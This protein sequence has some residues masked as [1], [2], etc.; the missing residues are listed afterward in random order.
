LKTAEAKVFGIRSQSC[1]VLQSF[2]R[3]SSGALQALGWR[4]QDDADFLRDDAAVRSS[5]ADERGT[6]SNMLSN[7]L[8]TLKSI[9]GKKGFAHTCKVKPKGQLSTNGKGKKAILQKVPSAP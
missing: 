5:V 7:P 9:Q 3:R 8:I 1:F 2:F 4:D 6:G